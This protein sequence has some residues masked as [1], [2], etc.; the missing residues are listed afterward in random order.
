MYV[1]TKAGSRAMLRYSDKNIGF[2]YSYIFL[3][4]LPFLLVL[5]LRLYLEKLPIAFDNKRHHYHHMSH[6]PTN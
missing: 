3:F 6:D 2:C 1:N 4:H 5:G